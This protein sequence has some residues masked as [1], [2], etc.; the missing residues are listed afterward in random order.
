MAAIGLSPAKAVLLAVQ[1]SRK[2]EIQNLRDLIAQNRTALKTN[3][4]LRILLSHLPETLESAAYVPFLEDLA[5]N[6]IVGDPETKIDSSS[7]DQ[8]DEFEAKKRVKKLHLLPLE[9]PHAPADIPDDSFVQFV[10]HRSLCIDK[11]T[12]LILQLPELLIPF[13]DRSEL[14]RSWTISTILPLLRFYYEYHPHD[15]TALTIAE[16]EELDDR[17]GVLLLLSKTANNSHLGSNNQ[18]TA[19]RDIRGLVGPW[20][21]G[22]SKSKRRKIQEIPSPEAQLIAPLD[23][24]DSENYRRTGWEEVFKW[25]TSQAIT[26]WRTAVDAVE[27]WDG[28]SDIDLGGL[29]D[30]SVWLDETE[31]QYLERRY[32]RATLAA[33]YLVSEGST[34]ALTG[35]HRILAR[36]ITLLDLDRI[37]PVS[38]A[39][40]LLAP[41]PHLDDNGILLPQNAKFLRNSLLDESNPLTSPNEDSIRL[42]HALLISAYIL[43]KS[44]QSCTIRRAGELV[45]QQDEADQKSEF[46]R[47]IYTIGNGPKADDKYWV[48]T[49]N[50]ILWLRDWGAEELAEGVDADRGRGIFGL[51]RTNFLEAEILKVLLSN[52][53]YDLAR[54]I[55]VK[56]PEQPLTRAQLQDTI[57]A[58]AMNAYDNATNPNRT[59]G[60]VKKCNDILKAFPDTLEGSLVAEQFLHLL[61]VTHAIEKYSLVLTKG[62]PFTPVHLRV[63]GDPISIIDKILSQNPKAYTR[64]DDFIRL[65]EGMVDAGLVLREANGRTVKDVESSDPGQQELL[66]TI[67]LEEIQNQKAVA[68]KRIIGMCIVNSLTQD[69]FE[70][71]YSYVVTRLKSTAAPAHEKVYQ[72]NNTSEKLF[73][74]LPPKSIDEWSWLAAF[75]AGKYKPTGGNPVQFGN[76]IG[77]PQIRHLQQRIECLSYALR[78]APKN[79][80]QE[81]LSVYRRCEEELTSLIQQEEEAEDAW[82]TQGD[83]QAMPGGFGAPNLRGMDSKARGRD[84]E[85]APMSLFSLSRATASRAHSSL[86]ALTGLRSQEGR[87][88]AISPPADV[89]APEGSRV[90][91]PDSAAQMRKRDQ[92]KQAATNAIFS[93]VGWVI[94]APKSENRPSGSDGAGHSSGEL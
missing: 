20:M 32:A 83:E 53:R 74:E 68:R 3:I 15:A 92:V 44:G 40:A 4:I 55:Y 82:D 67:R 37:P 63:H 70:T 50:E 54:A 25:I 16:L 48:K 84:E 11:N 79:T 27:D 41:I 29:E 46:R 30:G 39:A 18:K 52:T 77:N 89:G 75:Q 61:D 58:A 22:E 17:A 94:G 90:S 14:L 73:A 60:G 33:A 19:G 38:A 57:L 86:A 59:R 62:E 2:S 88:N 42:L 45:L 91:T 49:R 76:P 36:I 85:E 9:W 24:E 43:S 5:A 13:L 12:G 87:L 7:I 56:S 78:L 81:V 47:L 6:E 71:A 26:S 80:L 93:G 65:G 21:Y 72:P 23:A 64:A 34:E 35:V 66:K 31:Q 10:I 1:L 8:L 51:V 69:D 28:P